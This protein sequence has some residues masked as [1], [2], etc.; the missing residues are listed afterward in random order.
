MSFKVQNFLNGN[1]H[2]NHEC[3]KDIFL[4]D[5]YETSQEWSLGFVEVHSGFEIFRMKFQTLN[6]H[7]YTYPNKSPNF[8][9]HKYL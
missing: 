9:R 4:S 6:A 5:C 2:G 7:Y 1:N 3:S 8:G